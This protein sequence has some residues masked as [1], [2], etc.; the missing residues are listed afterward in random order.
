MEEKGNR[1]NVG[2]ECLRTTV[3]CLRPVT[4]RP[5]EDAIHSNVIV[6]RPGGKEESMG[7]D[8]PEGIHWMKGGMVGKGSSVTE[9]KRG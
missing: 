5:H 1:M 4:L 7:Q 9:L 3:V 8:G 2:E 6:S